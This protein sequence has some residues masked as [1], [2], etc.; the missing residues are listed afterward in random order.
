MT[1]SHSPDTGITLSP[2]VLNEWAGFELSPHQLERLAKALPFSSVPDAVGTIAD[3][4]AGPASE[5]E[6]PTP[7]RRPIMPRTVVRPAVRRP[8]H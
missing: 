6:R 8:R 4:L 2:A 7:H 5:T 1:I 3:S